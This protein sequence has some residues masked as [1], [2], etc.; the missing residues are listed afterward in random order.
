[1]SRTLTMEEWSELHRLRSSAQ[2]ILDSHESSAAID[3]MAFR[4]IRYLDYVDYIEIDNNGRGWGA[5]IGQS[6]YES[7]P[8][9]EDAVAAVFLSAT[10]DDFK[11][12][13][14][15]TAIVRGS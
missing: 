3:S 13:G 12:N 7:S 10:L 6:Y 2:N 1:V 11:D 15:P 4:L 9:L 14:P 5:M 8:S